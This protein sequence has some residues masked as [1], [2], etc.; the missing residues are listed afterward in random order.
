MITS[1]STFVKGNFKI[2]INFKKKSILVVN[3]AYKSV[4]QEGN[5]VFSLVLSERNGYKYGKKR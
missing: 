3:A 2:C 1:N 5:S 4:K